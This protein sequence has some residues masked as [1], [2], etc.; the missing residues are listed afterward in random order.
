MIVRYREYLAALD[1]KLDEMFKKQAPFIKCKKGCAFCCKDG[2]FPISELEYIGIMFRY[3]ELEDSIKEKV[4]ANINRLLKS[5]RTKM[6]EC[7]F[8]VDN[9]CSVYKARGIICRTFG[10]I[11]YYG[12]EHSKMPFCVEMDLNYAEVYD[13]ESEKIVKNASDGTI[14]TA[15]NI[16]RRTLRNKSVEKEFHILFG[17]D[18]PLIEWLKEDFKVDEN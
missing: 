2:E 16:D 8:L 4:D 9:I 6:Y 17:E 11:S 18:K 5:K 10:L 12:N 13:K 14:P 3:E 15:F 7:P 1:K